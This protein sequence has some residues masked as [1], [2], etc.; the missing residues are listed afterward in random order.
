M[1]DGLFN[2]CG[3]RTVE[4]K[5]DDKVYRLSIR[6][7][8]GFARKEAAIVSRLGNPYAGI[9]AIADTAIRTQAFRVAADVAARPVIATLQDEERFDQSMKGIAWSVFEALS[10]EHPVEFPPGLPVDQCIQLGY[11]FLN[12]FGDMNAVMNALYIVEEKDILKNSNG[13]EA[14]GQTS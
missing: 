6:T 14:A 10:E 11:D 5:K 7:N 8:R 9:D 1:A 13:P 4:L 2:L 12:W 3:R